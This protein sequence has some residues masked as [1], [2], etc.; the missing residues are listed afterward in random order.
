VLITDAGEPVAEII[1]F[2]GSR[3]PERWLGC[4]APPAESSETSSPLRL[5]SRIGKP[6]ASKAAALTFVTVDDLI[7]RSKNLPL[8]GSK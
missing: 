4:C 3:K 7:V 8:L 6:Y 5:S 1:P 2:P